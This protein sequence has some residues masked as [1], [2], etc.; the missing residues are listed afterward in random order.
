MGVA[1]K[2]EY[3][4]CKRI[5]VHV[6]LCMYMYVYICKILKFKVIILY[7][8]MAH[9]NGFLL[10]F[11]S[12]S[13]TF[14][15]F[16]IHYK[17]INTNVAG[18]SQ[19]VV[20]K[21]FKITQIRDTSINYTPTY[22]NISSKTPVFG[23]LNLDNFSQNLTI[24]RRK[25]L[26]YFENICIFPD[27]NSESLSNG[28]FH[29]NLISFDTSR[30]KVIY[31]F[32]FDTKAAKI[33]GSYWKILN[34]PDVYLPKGAIIVNNSFLVQCSSIFYDILEKIC[35]TENQRYPKNQNLYIII[36]SPR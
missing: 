5:H 26:E 6:H 3:G 23:G 17:I 24:F 30:G 18:K 12:F 36:Q 19:F 4:T 34:I 11:L 28:Q 7:P 25:H 35:I 29:G 21:K 15:F 2:R 10:L 8:N 27:I 33:K 22:R 13:I 20:S 31:K 14:Q 16:M 1:Y 9:C 32:H